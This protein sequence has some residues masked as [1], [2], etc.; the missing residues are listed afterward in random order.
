MS[1]VRLIVDGSLSE[2]NEGDSVRQNRFHGWNM[3][4]HTCTRKLGMFLYVGDR[5]TEKNRA[6]S[7]ELEKS[8]LRGAMSSSYMQ[9]QDRCYRATT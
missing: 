8:R 6:S 4:G 1:S 7:L 2:N 9:S 5:T 3:N